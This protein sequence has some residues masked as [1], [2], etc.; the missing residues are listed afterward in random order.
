M[1]DL[2]ELMSRDVEHPP[3][4]DLHMHS[5]FSD[6]T[7]SP[8]GLIEKVK[9]AG[10]DIFSITD[11][12][13]TKGCRDM[14]GNIKE[15]DP[16]FVPGVEFSTSDEEGKYHILGYDYDVDS[17]VMAEMVDRFH[18][19]RMYKLDRRIELLKEYYGFTFTDE[20][21]EW[22]YAQNNPGKPH[23]ANLMVR[24]GYAPDITAAIDNY[25][26]NCRVK[27]KSVRPEEAIEAILG[28]GGIPV[29]AHGYFGDG[30]QLLSDHEM[31]MRLLRLED[32]G[33]R[34][35]ECFYSGFSQK[36]NRYMLYLAGKYNFLATAGSDYHGT[37]KNVE[38]GDLGVDR[39]VGTAA[40]VYMKTIDFFDE[41]A[42]QKNRR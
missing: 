2:K 17:P 10:I 8:A 39:D 28:S 29:L 6:G 40:L 42:E 16:Y 15:D 25:V 24:H 18:E 22:L 32:M 20:D 13:E 41:I 33:L 9:A 5:S 27:Y 38:L 14:L 26:S 3:V 19:I 4:M 7:D 12:D 35:I 21:M 11:H 34:G 1:K 23:I 31:E 30:G 37:N 36:M